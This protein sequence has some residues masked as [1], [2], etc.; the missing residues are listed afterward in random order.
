MEHGGVLGTKV[1]VEDALV[2]VDEVMSSDRNAVAPF[3][4]LSEMKDIHCPVFGNIPLFGY[5][6][7]GLE[8][9][10]VFA[11][12]SLEE[13]GQDVVGRDTVGEVRIDGLWFRSQPEVQDLVVQGTFH[14]AFTRASR[15]NEEC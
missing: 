10:W 8:S 9:L 2:G 3:C 15:E 11:H 14:V 7:G 4:V 1:R 5:A 12:Q 13:S 6:R